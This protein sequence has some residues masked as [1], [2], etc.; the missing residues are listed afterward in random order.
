MSASSVFAPSCALAADVAQE[1][2]RAKERMPLPVRLAVLGVVLNLV[3][4]T[5]LLYICGIDYSAPG[6]NPLMKFHPGTYALL[7]AFGA[8]LFDGRRP[9]YNFGEMWKAERPTIFFLG[10]IICCALSG[11]LANGVSGTAVYVENFF[12]PAIFLL[13]FQRYGTTAMLRK[14]GYLLLAL[15]TLNVVISM[16]ETGLHKRLVPIYLMDKLMVEADSEFRGTGLYDHPL[17]GAATTMVAVIMLLGM[18]VKPK[19]KAL[20]AGLLLIGLISFGGR[21]ALATTALVMAGWG[22]TVMVGRFLRHEVRPRDLAV[23]LAV[24]V[25]VPVLMA[26]VFTQTN[27]GQR[28][29]LHMYWDESASTRVIQWQV[30]THMTTQEILFGTPFERMRNIVF[31]IGLE[32]PFNDIENFWLLLFVNLGLIGYLFFLAG[33]LVFIRHLWKILPVSGRI[34]L[35]AVLIVA[36]SSN[37]LGRKSNQLTIAVPAMLALAAFRK[38]EEAAAA[39]PARTGARG[40]FLSAETIDQG[41]AP[42]HPTVFAEAPVVGAPRLFTESRPLIAPGDGRS[43]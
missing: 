34:L 41:V 15:F 19:L 39:V 12:P 24:L 26:I 14:V 11:M 23:M 35:V 1:S 25:G 10:M 20:L 21:T 27:F 8:M 31:Q 36:S 7:L 2:L 16:I 17:T 40:L 28:I 4:S 9:L 22:G 30:L 42:P 13:V 18:D 3:I 5:N 29:L 43:S 6:G 33:F 32:L 38:P 37:S